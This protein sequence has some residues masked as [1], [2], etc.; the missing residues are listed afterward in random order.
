MTTNES[1]M[2]A[3]FVADEIDEMKDVEFNDMVPSDSNDPQEMMKDLSKKDEAKEMVT[4]TDIAD[5]E[6]KVD[7]VGQNSDDKIPGIG[8]AFRTYEEASNFYKQYA[9]RVGFGVA[10]KKSSFSKSGVCRRLILGCSKGGRGRADA[11]YLARQTAKT[12]CEAMIAVKLW[13]DG[14]LHVVD[15]KLEHNHPV[16]PSTAQFLRCYQK[17]AHTMNIVQQGGHRNS[18]VVDK[19]CVSMTEIGRL[20]LGEGDDEA[21]HQFFARMQNKNPKFFYSVDLDQNGRM[22]NLF[23]A[24][25]R[26]RAANRYFGDVVA[27]DSTCLTEKQD[28]PLVSFVGVNH[29]GQSVLLGCGLLSNE[30]VETFVWFFKTWLTCMMNCYPNAIITDLCKPIQDAVAEV[31]QGTRHRLCLHNVMKKVP[32]K[33]RGHEELKAIKKELKKLVYDSLRA[34]EFEHEWKKMIKKFGLEGNDWLTELYEN[35]HSWVPLFLKDAFWA[36]MSVAQR[37]ESLSTYFDGFV[38]PRTTIKHFF[39]KYE[40]IIQSKCKKEAQADSESFHKTPLIASKFYMEE[41]LSKLYTINMFQKFQDELKATMYCHASPMKIDGSIQIFEVKECSYIENGKRTESKDHEVFYNAEELA[42]QCICGFFQFHGILCRHSLSVFKLQQ[43]FEIPSHY[44]LNRWKKD[45]KRLH[46]LAN[47]A[48][49][50]VP[51]SLV[52]RHDYLSMR[53]LQLVEVGFLSEDRYQLAVKLIRELEKFLLDEP[54]CRDRQ[55]RL[56]SFETQ[57]GQCVQDLLASRF[58]ISECNKSQSSLQAKRRG[59]PQKKLE[60]SNIEALVR[61]N[62]EQD[63]LRSSLIQSENPVLQAASTSLHQDA[64]IGSQ[65]GIDLMEEV[66]QNELSFG[67]HFGMHVNQDQIVGQVRMQPSNLFQVQYEQQGL[68]TPTRMPWLYHQLYQ[69][70]QIPKAPSGQRNG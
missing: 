18:H 3:P 41:Q 40:T 29:H 12:N 5:D 24:D 70:D 11:C 69:E 61:A 62:K 15:A 52:D 10:V 57:P 38:Y 55:S 50:I 23:W 9:L 33:V 13:G 28:L 44:I 17:M 42:V 34:Y 19:D 32:E 21:I 63:F 48:D 6:E 49:D 1:A 67:P 20:K 60:E 37:G 26:S 30:T 39:S 54:G 31:F 4:T 51:D 27:F 64:H 45:F 65:G 16:S 7:K 25:A 46:T 36:G 53:F 43:I 68:S 59:R 35:R 8:M 56:L 47:Y 22:R 58:V 14:L 2:E 66:N